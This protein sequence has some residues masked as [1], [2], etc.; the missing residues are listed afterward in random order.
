MKKT[1]RV[2]LTVAFIFAIATIGFANATPR[3]LKQANLLYST[4]VAPVE[5][6]TTP[7]LPVAGNQVSDFKL[8]LDGSPTSWYYLDIKFIKPTLPEGVYMFWLETPPATGDA[9]YDYWDAKGVNVGATYPN[10]QWF[11][12]RIIRP[13]GWNTRIP[14][15]GLYSDGAGNYQLRDGLVHFASGMTVTSPLRLN[16]DYPKGT[17]TF[18]C[19][20]ATSTVAPYP[21]LAENVLDGVSMTIVFR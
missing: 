5:V 3:T 9:F 7:W 13:T 18:T 21:P 16:G 19:Y 2:L 1:I 14:M 4:S 6:P 20:G 10:W 8:K 17:Y 12:W 15:F 11:M